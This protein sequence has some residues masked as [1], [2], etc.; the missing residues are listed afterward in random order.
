MSA[1][2]RQLE[3]PS[4]RALADLYDAQQRVNAGRTE[5]LLAIFDPSVLADA[6]AHIDVKAIEGQ[7]RD[8]WMRS[9]DSFFDW[10]GEQMGNVRQTYPVDT[11][12][13]GDMTLV[14]FYEVFGCWTGGDDFQR[15]HAYHEMKRRFFRDSAAAFKSAVKDSRREQEDLLR[16]AW[17][18]T[19]PAR[20]TT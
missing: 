14:P 12:G 1:L 16:R 18:E 4:T 15:G 13:I 20:S 8:E 6:I 11:Q 7:L 9:P 17:E 10:L 2:L 3:T 19:Q 5:N